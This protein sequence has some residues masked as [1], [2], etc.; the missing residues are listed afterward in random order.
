MVYTCRC[1][2]ATCA[3]SGIGGINYQVAITKRKMLQI[4][5]KYITGDIN[6][7]TEITQ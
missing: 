6:M 5:R 7:M 1:V 2:L 3:K 4:L